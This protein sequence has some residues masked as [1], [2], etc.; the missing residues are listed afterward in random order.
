MSYKKTSPRAENGWEKCPDRSGP[1]RPGPRRGHTATRVR[2]VDHTTVFGPLQ[3]NLEICEAR[4]AAR[5]C[6]FN[7]P[8]GLLGPSSTLGNLLGGQTVVK[9][10]RGSSL[11]PAPP[12]PAWMG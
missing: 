11:A 6:R 4:L 8:T 9:R 10:T 1:G 3:T 7:D 2:T 5:V 12:E